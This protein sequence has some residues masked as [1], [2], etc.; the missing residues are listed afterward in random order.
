MLGERRP[1]GGMPVRR[2]HDGLSVQDV[3]D[4]TKLIT[5]L[6]FLAGILAALPAGAPQLALLAMIAGLMVQLAGETYLAF[7]LVS[8]APAAV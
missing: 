8:A 4:E 7:V 6:I 1:I 5:F 2:R 3:V